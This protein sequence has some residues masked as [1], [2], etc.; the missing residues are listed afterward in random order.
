MKK[1]LLLFL[2]FLVS[3]ALRVYKLDNRGLITDEKFTLLNA[4][5]FWVGGYN[6]KAFKQEYFTPEDFWEEKGVQDYFDAIANSDFGTHIV[7]NAFLHPWMKFFG[8]SDFSVRFPSVIFNVLNVLLIFLLVLKYFK[9]YWMAFLAGLLFAVDP[10]NVAQSHIARSY[11]LSFLLITLSTEYFIRIVKNGGTFKNFLI[12]TILIGLSLINHYFNFFIPLAHAII[13]LFLRNKQHLWKGFIL[14]ALANVCLLIY[15]FNWGGGYSA[16]G[17]LEHKN[18]IHQEIAQNSKDDLSNTIEL[19]RTDLIIKKSI[20]LYYDISVIGHDLYKKINGAKVFI[21]SFIVFLA[22]LVFTLRKKNALLRW[23]SILLI[24]GILGSQYVHFWGIFCSVAI[25]YIILFSLKA[26]KESYYNE[27]QKGQF[28]L[29]AIGLIMLTF[30]ILFVIRDAFSSGTMISLTHRY[31]GNSSPFTVVFI[32]VGI[33]K[34]VEKS[35]WFLGLFAILFIVQTQSIAKGI[36]NYYNDESIYNAY[37]VP[38]RV[39]NPYITV[40]KKIEAMAIPGDTLIIPG[41]YKDKYQERYNKNM[42]VSA[43]DAQFL[44]LYFDKDFKI[45]ETIDRK[46]RERLYLKRKS[47]EK[48]LIFDFK[49]EEYRY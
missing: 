19:A 37:F 24:L 21:V 11:P 45:I 48:I 27:A 2:L 22:S 43:K 31:I 26:L 20:G 1:Y 4:N 15:W 38:K 8:N 35:K 13:F 30:P 46:E 49:G 17:F 6:Q 34:A 18:K 41:A 12:Y 14:A 16:L 9:N 42:V 28:M 32:A 23:L 25:F 47:G 3:F 33:V 5:G 36:N 7:Y 40:A 10:L 29:L 44:N 39:K